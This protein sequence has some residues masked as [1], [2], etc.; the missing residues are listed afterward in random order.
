MNAHSG[1]I[2]RGPRRPLPSA[3]IGEALIAHL[4]AGLAEQADRLALARTAT[5][6]VT[7]LVY[8]S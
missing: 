6:T 3:H 1:I 2:H 8:A 4:I 7:G 5:G